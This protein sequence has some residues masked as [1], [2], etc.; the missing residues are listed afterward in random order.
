MCTRCIQKKRDF[1]DLVGYVYSIFNFFCTNVPNI[2]EVLRGLK[3]C[4]R[5]RIISEGDYIEGDKIDIDN[6]IN[7]IQEK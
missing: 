1:S 4:R 2:S 5:K 6:Q 3:K 7:I